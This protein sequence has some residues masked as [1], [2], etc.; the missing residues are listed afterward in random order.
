M[1]QSPKKIGRFGN[2]SANITNITHA[3]GQIKPDLCP[4]VIQKIGYFGNES[5]SKAAADIC[6]ML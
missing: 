3:I 5:A 2:K 1:P 6:T 4:R